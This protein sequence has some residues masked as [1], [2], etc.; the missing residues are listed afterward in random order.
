MEAVAERTWSKYQSDIYDAVE[1]T[2]ESLIVEAV[3]GSG[4]TT[5]LVECASRLTEFD[6]AICLAFNVRIKDELIKRLPPFI[7]ALT[8]NSLGYRAWKAFTGKQMEV[9]GAKVTKLVRGML[10]GSVETRKGIKRLVDLAKMS[11]VVPW[12]V[13]GVTG[14]RPDTDYTWRGLIAEYGLTFDEMGADEAVEVARRV[15]AESIRVGAERVDFN[16]QMYLPVVFGA[17][18]PQY[19]TLFVD[20]AQDV[21]E[22]QR[23]MIE[24]SVSARGRVIAFGDPAQA[25]YHFRGAGQDSLPL[26]KE[27]FRARSMPLSICYRCS[28]AVVREA[29]QYVSTIE[30]FEEAP[31]GKVVTLGKL[32]WDERTFRPTDVI[33]CRNNAPIVALAFRLLRAGVAVRVLGRDIGAGLIALVQRL[34]AS[35]IPELREKLNGYVEKEVAKLDE[36]Q[37]GAFFDRIDTL[38]VF[39]DHT[40]TVFDLERKIESLFGDDVVGLTLSTAHRA[41]GCEWPRVFILNRDLIGARARQDWEKQ[42]ERNVAYVA[43]TRAQLELYYIKTGE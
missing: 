6:S 2:N 8:F 28:K 32:A 30:A 16:D 15:L 3:A 25:L 41:K 5:C 38:R 20:E 14:L 26:L 19:D 12:Y 37:V 17:D 40:N 24:R 10:N 13:Q 11:G 18:F 21:S 1:K 23:V 43:V 42:A 35:T 39:I 36:D 29:Q 34:R 27:R 7:S 31:E 33:L 4:K 22:I 9:D